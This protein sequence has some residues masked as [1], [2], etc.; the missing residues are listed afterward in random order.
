MERLS[1][2]RESTER[3]EKA[4]EV[5][6]SEIGRVEKGT[7]WEGLSGRPD[8][9]TQRTRDLAREM[10]ESQGAEEHGSLIHLFTLRQLEIALGLISEL[11]S[12]IVVLHERLEQIEKNMGQTGLPSPS[13]NA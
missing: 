7:E 2:L 13:P 6:R 11:S 4:V 10:A 9:G 3:I 8:T 12:H 5:V 1:A